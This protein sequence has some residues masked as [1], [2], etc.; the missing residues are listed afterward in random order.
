VLCLALIAFVLEE[1]AASRPVMGALRRPG[2]PGAGAIVAAGLTG[3]SIVAVNTYLP[4]FI[5][6]GR[7][8]PVIV[9]GAILT[10]GSLAW[11]AGSIVSA[12]FMT[13]GTRLL[14]AAGHG[15]F[16]SG[17][18]ILVAAVALHA[19]LPALFAG[20]MLTGLGTGVLTPSLFTIALS[21]VPRDAAG[22]AT[23]GVQ[24]LRALG[25]GIG[26]GVAGLTFRLMVP[27]ELFSLLSSADPAAAIRAAGL[28]SFLDGALIACWL[29]AA[30]F[31]ALSALVVLRLRPVN[32]TAIQTLSAVEGPA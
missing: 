21:D 22:M 24:V 14:L 31:V 12:R 26:A 19:P 8:E 6:A 4:L 30:A 27:A 18:L 1:R 2:S 9:A 17:A 5:Q 13:Y 29:V 7:G 16:V 10:V 20:I 25:N 28:G 11:S 3:V 23:A 32:P 15:F